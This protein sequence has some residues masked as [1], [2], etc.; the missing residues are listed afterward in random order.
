MHDIDRRLAE[1]DPVH[2][3]DVR[4]A[5]HS[6]DAVALLQR[7]LAEPA[8]GTPRSRALTRRVRITAT[9]PYAD[10][11]ARRRRRV[12]LVVAAVVAIAAATG[13]AWAAFGGSSPG[14]DTTVQCE[15]NGADTII[16]SITGDPVSDCAVTWQR[17]TGQP[18]PKLLPYRAGTG[19]IVVL[20]S[21]QVPPAG[22]QLLPPGSGQDPRLIQLQEAL[23]DYVDGLHACCYSDPVAITKTQAVLSGLGLAG[24][25]VSVSSPADGETSCANYDLT[26][27]DAHR[28]ELGSGPPAPPDA[29]YV[30]LGALIRQ[31][32]SC[33]SLTVAAE[34]VRADARQLGVDNQVEINQVTEPNAPCTSIY[35]TVGGAI[36]ITL[37]GPAT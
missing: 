2:A 31:D 36:F 34:R 13:A 35:E 25:T 9:R 12:P 27:V 4:G 11:R 37:R 24:W 32:G 3:Q 28:I 7:I 18:A 1:L 17:D 10:G 5:A 30:Q 26:D 15:I 6:P 21:T 20:P 19:E 16:D 29:K 14:T 23:D 8:E 22:Y 33:Q